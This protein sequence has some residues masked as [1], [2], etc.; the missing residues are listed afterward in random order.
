METKREKIAV[1]YRCGS[2]QVTQ[3]TAQRKNGYTV[4]R[5]RCDCGEEVLLDTR[6]LQRGTVRDCGCKTKIKP[7]QRD[8]TGLRFGRLTA[9]YP[10]SARDAS[11]AA[12]WHCTCDCGGTIDAP[13]HQLT[14]GYRKSCGCLSH[15][16]VRDY[17]GKRFS[18]LLVI[19][20]AGK[21]DGQHLWRCRCDCG[22]ETVVRQTYLQSGKTKSCGCLQKRQ[23]L[24]NLKLCG[25]TSVT[26]LEAER[27]RLLRSNTSGV[28]GVYQNRRTQKWCAQITFQRKTYYLGSFEQKS[29]AVNARR[30]GEA[31][32]EAFLQWYYETHSRKAA[33]EAS[34]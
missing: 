17:V 8:I 24:Q 28:T 29:D 27:N 9:Q 1:G 4:W 13:L 33:K 11:G 18:K 21:A 31:M 23:I 7:G 16:P 5:C 2:L 14:A 6:T 20:Y 26:L 22:N 15:P 19:A 12:V 34:V 25:G 30:Q 10:L 3:A 32:H